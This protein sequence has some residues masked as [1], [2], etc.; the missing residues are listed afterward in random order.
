MTRIDRRALF[1]SGAAAALLAASGVSLDARP[2][3]GG[4]LRLAVPRDDA[5]LERVARAAIF[6]TLTE[7]A[8][9]GVLRGELAIGWQGSADA[10]VWTFDLRAGVVFHDG[11]LLTARDVAA[12]LRAHRGPTL[13]GVA[14]ITATGPLRVRL[15]LS[16]GNPDL[17]YMLA[18]PGL[19][20]CRDGAVDI[21]LVR[22]N[23][24]GC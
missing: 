24:T 7:I 10:R 1:A 6:D 17:P 18:D 12:S 23:G 22:A 21:S 3:S 9:D 13:T 8:P 2:R 20:I 16:R 19:I 14:D 11:A 15:E 4:R 5:S